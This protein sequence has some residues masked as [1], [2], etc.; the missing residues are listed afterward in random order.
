LAA[1]WP[2]SGVYRERGESIVEAERLT[3]S[4]TEAAEVIG[5]SRAH[6]YEMVRVGRIPSIRLGRRV[7]V[8]RKALEKFLDAAVSSGDAS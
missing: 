4:V 5:I 8:P 3:M 2:I 7:V 1:K 6:A